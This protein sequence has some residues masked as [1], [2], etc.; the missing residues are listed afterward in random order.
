MKFFLLALFLPAVGSA[1]ILPDAAG[2]Y[3]RA[4]T[5]QPALTD[6]AIWDEYGLK[7]SETASYEKGKSK[8][9]ATVWQMQDPT[10]ALAAFDWQRPAGA[11]PSTAAKLAAETADS[12]VVVQGNYLLSFV[13]HKPDKTELDAVLASL[14]NVD[15]T[16]LP[17]LASYLPDGGLTPNTERYVTGPASLAK[18]A[19]GIPPSVAGF[20]MGAEAQIGVFHNAKGDATLAIFNYPTPQIA[21]QRTPEFEKLSGAMVKRSGPLVAVVVSPPDPDFAEQ[22]LGQIRYQAEVTRD[23]YVPTRRDNI[24]NLVINAFIL[25]G[26]LL[27]FCF[28]SGLALGAFRAIRKSV[29]PGSEPE[30]MITLHLENR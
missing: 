27:G 22:V 26:I 4:S 1:A 20:H 23:E 29:R 7:A 17:V 5:A 2:D 10:G 12:L 9:T 25:I 3:T 28:V 13:G 15:T 14:K 18:F 21:M 16:S 30:A 6:R 8:F 24:G 19:P 11:K